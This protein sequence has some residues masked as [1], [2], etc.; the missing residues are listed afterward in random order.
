MTSFVF[1]KLVTLKREKQYSEFNFGTIAALQ[2]WRQRETAGDFE[3]S[4]QAGD[5]TLVGASLLEE[6]MTMAAKVKGFLKKGDEDTNLI[7]RQR[8]TFPS[9]LSSWT[10]IAVRELWLAIISNS[11]VVCKGS[12]SRIPRFNGR[13]DCSFSTPPSM[14]TSS[15]LNIWLRSCTR[16]EVCCHSFLK[17]LVI[18]FTDF[19]P[20]RCAKHVYEIGMQESSKQNQ[21]C[22]EWIPPWWLTTNQCAHFADWVYCA[23]LKQRGYHK[24]SENSQLM[25]FIQCEVHLWSHGLGIDHE[26]GLGHIFL[27]PKL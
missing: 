9:D 1:P 10:A 27:W 23:T 25:H 8:H 4:L 11:F 22:H 15:L 6:K 19:G 17:D 3:W 24:S 20:H 14:T 7:G 26:I 16:A 18:S 2:H 12:I 5:P 21:S 13:E